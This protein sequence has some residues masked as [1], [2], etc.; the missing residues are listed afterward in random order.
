MLYWIHTRLE[1]IV[2]L[3]WMTSPTWCNKFSRIFVLNRELVLG[4]ERQNIWSGTLGILHLN[5]LRLYQFMSYSMYYY[6]IM[7]SIDT[8][9]ITIMRNVNL[10]IYIMIY[11]QLGLKFKPNLFSTC[12][13]RT[14]DTQ[15][16][17]YWFHT[18]YES[19]R[20]TFCTLQTWVNFYMHAPKQNYGGVCSMC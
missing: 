17:W 12:E 18:M 19:R 16:K 8:W 11:T 14:Y 3:A 20:A 15:R 6:N 4:I 5:K 2:S 7:S 13:H 9:G 10:L 1:L